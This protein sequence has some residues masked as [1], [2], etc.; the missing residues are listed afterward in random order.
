MMSLK[1]T[2]LTRQQK[3]TMYLGQMNAM[4]PSL[5]WTLI[6]TKPEGAILTAG[7][8]RDHVGHDPGKPTPG[9]ATTEHLLYSQEPATDFCLESTA[10]SQSLFTKSLHINSVLLS[11]LSTSF[12]NIIF[13]ILLYAINLCVSLPNHVLI[14]Y[15][16]N[17]FR[18]YFNSRIRSN[19]KISVHI[20]RS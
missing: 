10:S 20:I 3:K 16:Q 9:V 12:F 8:P 5:A 6:T 2:L 11:T 19:M 14:I 1:T 17:F 15:A 18:Y 4:M 13:I 7:D